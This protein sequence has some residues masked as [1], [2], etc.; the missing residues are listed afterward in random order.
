METQAPPFQEAHLF[1][2]PIR[3]LGLRIEGTPLEPVVAEFGE[4]LV[5]AGIRKV[6]RPL[7]RHV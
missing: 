6:R 5:R 7:P 1:S 3:D 4:E 2:R